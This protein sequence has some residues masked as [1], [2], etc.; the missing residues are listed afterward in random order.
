MQ[1]DTYR[2][3]T[4]AEQ[5]TL[6]QVETACKQAHLAWETQRT[7]SGQ[8]VGYLQWL[9]RNQVRLDGLPSERKVEL[10]LAKRVV[11][12]RVSASTRD[13][14]FYALLFLYGSVLKRDLGPIRQIAR[15]RRRAHLPVLLDMEQV[16]A[17]LSAVTESITC[18]PRT[19][20]AFQNTRT[21][22]A[23]EFDSRTPYGFLDRYAWQSARTLYA[24]GYVSKAKRYEPPRRRSRATSHACHSCASYA[25]ISMIAAASERPVE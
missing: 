20:Y 15:S 4:P 17:V 19:G 16:L 24:L 22:Y 7:Y 23:H 8:I 1:R 5:R 13:Q 2:N 25:S 6:L 10:F 11:H 3:L 9:R 14:A 12:D 21:T 18:P